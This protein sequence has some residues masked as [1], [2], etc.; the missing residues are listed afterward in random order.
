MGSV[1]FG[2]F[3]LNKNMDKRSVIKKVLLAF[4]QSSTS[5][6]YDAIYKYNDG[7]NQIKQITVSFGITEYGNLKKLLTSYVEKGG[8]FKSSFESYLPSIG[9][10]PLV[11]DDK[12]VGLLKESASDPLMQMCQESAY[13]SM[14]IEPAYKFCSSNGFET[15]LSKLVICDS[16]LHSGSIL[17]LLRNK[18]SESVPAKGGDEKVWTKSYC[19]ARKK[20]LANHSNKILNKTVYRMDFMLDLINKGD[21][22][23]TQSPLNANGVKITN[24]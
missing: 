1:F 8:R 11:S 16:Y 5:I 21:W 2:S 12:F 20:W 3:Y 24:A 17:S 22:D 14:Y 4:E 19:E 18:F 15:N 23:L 6:K 10:K 9:V 7:P 13:E